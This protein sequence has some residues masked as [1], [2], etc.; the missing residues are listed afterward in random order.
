[1]NINKII[2]ELRS[3]REDIERA[4]TAVER[5]GTTAEVDEGTGRTHG[6]TEEAIQESGGLIL[7]EPL[8]ALPEQNQCAKAGNALDGF[9]LR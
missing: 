3:E 7:A 2:S 9:C 4:I 5:K 1:M 6:G 8:P